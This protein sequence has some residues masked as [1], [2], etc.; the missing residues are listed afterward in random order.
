MKTDLL[1][2]SFTPSLAVLAQWFKR[3]RG[4]AM[5]MVAAS[6]SIG[7]VVYTVMVQHLLPRIGFAWAVRT[8]GFVSMACLFV[9]CLTVRTR[10]PLSR[11][12]T[13]KGII[14]FHGFKDPQYSLA[15][16]GSFL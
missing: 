16:V 9:A 5:G 15:A 11:K 7:G 13:L 6:S 10:L 2:L 3:R 8:A 4:L 12:L 1:L 14:D